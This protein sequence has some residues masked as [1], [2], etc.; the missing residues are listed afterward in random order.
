MTLIRTKFQFH[1][2]TDLPQIGLT[3]FE[4]VYKN[5]FT[6][7]KKYLRTR[8]VLQ[9]SSMNLQ[10]VPDAHNVNEHRLLHDVVFKIIMIQSNSWTQTTTW[11]YRSTHQRC[12]VKKGALGKFSK[13]HRKRICARA[14]FLIKLQSEVCNFVKKE[15]LTQVFP[16]E[17]CEISKNT[18]SIEHLRVALSKHT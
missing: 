3:D 6:K 7:K 12:S 10:K 11:L 9:L 17:F 15:T 1:R 8:L 16:C 2:K 18:F 13:I 4:N 14:S 5:V